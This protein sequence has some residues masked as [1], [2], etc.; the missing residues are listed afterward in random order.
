[1]GLVVGGWGSL[2]VLFSVAS[3]L[4]IT[5]RQRAEEIGLL[6]VVGA[7]PRQARRLVLAEAAAVTGVGCRARRAGRLAGR[8]PAAR[9]AAQR[10]HG[11]RRR[12]VR[13]RRGRRSAAPSLLVVADQ[14]ARGRDHR[15]A[16]DER[17]GHPRASPRPA[18]APGGCRWW[19]VA[20]GLLLVAYGIGMAVVTITVTAHQDDP[21]AAMSHQRVELDPGRRRAGRPL[22]RAAALAAPACA[23]RRSVAPASSAGS[24]RT[25]PRAARSSSA[26]CSPR[27]SC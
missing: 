5:V 10:R 26:A 20:I 8:L 12:R 18:G 6:R 19:R 23:R 17:A 4:A 7:T 24:R 13:R 14:P 22:P 1:M 21:Y 2:I 11:R 3:T 16:Y 15:P 25:T 27:S 9:P